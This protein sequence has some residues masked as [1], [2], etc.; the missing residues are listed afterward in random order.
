MAAQ[1]L[2]P[3]QWVPG[4][5]QRA[6]SDS[7]VRNS[8]YLMAST[9]VTA[10]LG[11]VF[12]ALAAHAF[13]R[14]EVG[15][16]SAVISLCSTAA[17]LTYLGSSAMLI[18]RLPA[19]EHS[20]EWTTALVRV[21]LITTGVTATATAAAV[22]LLLAS[23]DYRFFFR[24]APLIIVAV[25]GAAAWTLVNLLGA[26]FIAARRAGRLLSM[27]TMISAAKVLIV[28]PLAAAGVGAAG[29]VEAWVASALLGVGVGAAWLVPQMGLGR[30]PGPRPRR[31]P[32][33]TPELRSHQYR[34]P[35]HRRN[36]A[37]P[38]AESMRHLLGQHLT[39]VG[40]AVTPLVLP[41]LVVL[42]LG[43]TLNA[44][45]YIT[46]MM[47]AAFFMVSPSVASAVFAEG[48]RARSDLRGVVAKAMRVIAAML[49]PAMAVM[50]VGGRLILGLFGSSYAVAGYG[51]L[52]LL[53]ISALPDAVSNVAVVI[54]RVTRRLGYSAV[55]NLGILVTTLVGA[56]VLMPSLGIAGVGVAW[57][58]AQTI[59]AIAS[60]PAYMQIRT[61]MIL[62]SLIPSHGDRLVTETMLDLGVAQL[63]DLAKLQSMDRLS[64][65]VL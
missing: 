9:V 24:T 20:S 50:I 37:P 17:L 13:T 26:A 10:G 31:R 38:S 35:R 59:G 16:G 7:L 54:C 12:W 61:P 1:R 55:L 4:Y 42:R 22:P 15:I 56:W 44:Y 23:E 30:R 8:S 29:I 53:A 51:L 11:Y 5:L 47:G 57:L 14:Q 18:E 60:L 58:G 6:R 3:I 49:A 33:V 32:P 34:R 19:S 43:V 45:F 46:W 40:G 28:L 52:I 27:Q 21:C 63:I 39:S 64:G 48:V 25:V 62:S 2:V 41:V 65:R 36:P